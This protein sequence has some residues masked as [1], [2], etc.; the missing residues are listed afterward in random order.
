MSRETEMVDVEK[1]PVR[2]KAD[3]GDEEPLPPNYPWAVDKLSAIPDPEDKKAHDCFY[4]I[5]CAS[6]A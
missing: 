2:G 3:E 6:S 4:H 1:T 5:V